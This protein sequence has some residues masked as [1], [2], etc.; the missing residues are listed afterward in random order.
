MKERVEYRCCPSEL[1]L[2][3]AS[4]S[5]YLKRAPKNIIRTRSRILRL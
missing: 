3:E 4:T 1:G 5:L 2:V